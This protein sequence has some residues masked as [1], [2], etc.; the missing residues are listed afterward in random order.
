M[1]LQREG[2]GI[3]G[4]AAEPFSSKHKLTTDEV[5]SWT[6]D[7]KVDRHHFRFILSPENGA[8]IELK[9]YA[10]RF[11]REMEL[12]L[13]TK[14]SWVAVTHHNTDNP[15]VHII[16]R[17]VDEDGQDL[18]ISRDYI[19]RGARI[20]AQELATRELGF[21]R[22]IDIAM[23][24]QR[25]ITKGRIVGVDH[26]LIK[27]S[28][29][30]PS[31]FVDMR[32]TPPPGRETMHKT[33]DLQLGRLSFLESLNLAVEVTSGVWKLEDGFLEKLRALGMRNDII[34]TMH[35]RMRGVNPDAQV[36]IFE[37]AKTP[38]KTIEGKVLHVG[39]VNELYETR[40]LM[41]ED[42]RRRVHYVSLA[43]P[44]TKCKRNLNIGDEVKVGMQKGQLVIEGLDRGRELDLGI[45]RK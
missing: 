34:K 20:K 44:D 8:E 16:V 2:V 25:S 11:M 14:L 33:R 43:A 9:A 10:R 35:Q 24:R 30:N 39:L 19:S 6:K 27:H 29:W 1:Y 40:Y 37:P 26:E 28:S 36:S 17:G 41:I 12:D 5:A 3:E 4:S 23:E 31:G 21:R 32:Q 7:A 45:E 42:Q 18:V 38:E 13:H 22:E 15:H